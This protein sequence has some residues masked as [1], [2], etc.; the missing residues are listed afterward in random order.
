MNKCIK[1]CYVFIF[2]LF[3]VGCATGPKIMTQHV[4]KDAKIGVVSFMGNKATIH[5]ASLFTMT[6]D[7]TVELNNFSYDKYIQRSLV[8]N[9]HQLGY[10]NAYEINVPEN[11]PISNLT[12][13]QG[14]FTLSSIHGKSIDYIKQINKLGQYDFVVIIEPNYAY[15]GSEA[16]SSKHF[17]YGIDYTNDALTGHDITNFA[18]YDIKIMDGNLTQVLG[19]DHN[20]TRYKTEGQVGSKKISE[21][22]PVVNSL[23]TW[24]KNDVVNDMRTKTINLLR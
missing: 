10:N 24:L 19:S 17:R 15:W 14:I 21:N 12:R 20:D 16:D 9:L 3:L 23:K 13:L 2:S 7:S 11:N 5:N 1:L 22:S 18:A 8:S 4:N 6:S